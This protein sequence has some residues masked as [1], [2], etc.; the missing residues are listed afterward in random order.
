MVE[1]MNHRLTADSWHEQLVSLHP[2]MRL[3]SVC[4][5]TPQV[6]RAKSE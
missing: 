1:R 3:G 2:Q 4:L 5:L 6:A